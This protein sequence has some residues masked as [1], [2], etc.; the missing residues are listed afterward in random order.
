MI[1]NKVHHVN[2]AC[3]IEI[4][5]IVILSN[6]VRHKISRRKVSVTI[7]ISIEEIRVW[8]WKSIV[9]ALLGI[10]TH[11]KTLPNFTRR[12]LQIYE[13]KGNSY[14]TELDRRNRSQY[15]TAIIVLSTSVRTKYCLQRV[16]VSLITTSHPQFKIL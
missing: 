9:R 16:W 8:K 15:Q 11:T 13:V 1:W 4:I 5:K 10:Q 14:C 12:G 2:I 7:F 3:Q 6:P